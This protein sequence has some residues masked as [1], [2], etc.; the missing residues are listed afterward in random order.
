MENFSYKSYWLLHS[1][2]TFT[3][4]QSPSFIYPL[5][6]TA[7]SS[8]P[9]SDFPAHLNLYVHNKKGKENNA[10]NQIPT[11]IPS[12]RK[13]KFIHILPGYVLCTK[14]KQQTIMDQENPLTESCPKCHSFN[15]LCKN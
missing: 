3:A 11:V 1:I 15:V 7:N 5:Q 9:A 13:G 10:H 8:L 6:K 4:K 12:L 14:H 2:Y